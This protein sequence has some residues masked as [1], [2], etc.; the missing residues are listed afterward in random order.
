MMVI[1][2]HYDNLTFPTYYPEDNKM[3]MT[4]SSNSTKNEW[5]NVLFG[6]WHVTDKLSLQ[7]ELAW[8]YNAFSGD[9]KQKLNTFRCQ[10]NLTYTTGPWMFAMNGKLKERTISNWGVKETTF[11]SW[12]LSAKYNVR[13]LTFEIGVG[14]LFADNIAVRRFESSSFSYNK[15]LCDKKDQGAAYLKVAWK[16]NKGKKTNRESLTISRDIESA[17]MK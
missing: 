2:N 1:Y 11:T 17:I 9:C 7:P 12:H 13:N 8:I 3:I 10:F 14:N 5:T 6:T 16:W 4:Y 15:H